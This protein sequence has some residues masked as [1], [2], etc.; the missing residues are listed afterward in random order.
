MAAPERARLSFE[1][2]A[3]IRQESGGSIQCGWGPEDVSIASADFAWDTCLA[4]TEARYAALVTALQAIA[5]GETNAPEGWYVN[6][7]LWARNALAAYEAKEPD[8]P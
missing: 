2:F 4:E 7:D 3:N 6:P 1:S 5:D 8:G